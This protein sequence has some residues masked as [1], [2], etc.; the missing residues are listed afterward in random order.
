MCK[1]DPSIKTP[2]CG[3]P[4]C[5][6]PDQYHET[7]GVVVGRFQT[8]YLHSGHMGIINHVFQRHLDV[9][10]LIGVKDGQ[11]TDRDPLSFAIRK[12]MIREMYLYTKRIEILRLPDIP[13]NDGA[14]SQLVDDIIDETFSERRATL[15]GGR[16]SFI[17]RYTG[18][19]MTEVIQLDGQ[20]PSATQLRSEVPDNNPG[21][22]AFREG[23]I[24]SANTRF[25][26]AY[27]AVDVAIVH[28]IDPKVLV[29]RKKNEV[30]W[31]FVGGFVD[32]KD[33]SLELAARREVIEETDGIEVDGYAYLGS[34]KI[35]DSRYRGTR[36]G[37]MTAFFVATYVFGAPRATDDLFDVMWLRFGEIIEKLIPAHRPLGVMLLGHLMKKGRL[38]E[39]KL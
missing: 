16:D 39:T 21:F 36:D 1:C 8:P 17:P 27:Q 20:H 22:R 6:W 7:V 19:Y 30:G 15:Y 25:P 13:G 2:F 24:H 10:I 29:G 31:R 33:G 26:T 18:H 4:G 37:V 38:K 32:P 3:K 23:M 35:D 9:L 11:P 34:H 5:E 12:T 28:S 14:W